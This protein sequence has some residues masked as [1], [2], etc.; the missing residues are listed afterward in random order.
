MLKVDVLNH[1]KNRVTDVAEACG[2]S[3]AAVSQW[4]DVIPERAALR[5][6]R[7]TNG[8]LKYI[9]KHYKKTSAA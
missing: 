1:F 8:K 3:S 5:L 6:D 2:V 9:A 7:Q 4:G